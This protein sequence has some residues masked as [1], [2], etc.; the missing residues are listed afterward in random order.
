MVYVLGRLFYY[1][2][3]Y[4]FFSIRRRHTRCALVTGVQTCALPILTRPHAITLDLGDVRSFGG[5]E[6]VVI[7]GD[8]LLAAPAI[9]VEAGVDDQARG[10]EHIG[11][12][13]AELAPRVV[14]VDAHLVGEL[15]GIKAP[16]LGIDRI[17][18]EAAEARDA[19]R[20]LRERDLV[21]MARRRFVIGQRR[22]RPRRVFGGVA[23]VD[24]ISAGARAV[25]SE[26]R[27]VGK[28]CVS[29][30]RSRW[31]PYH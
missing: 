26:E 13:I 18:G 21:V 16:A 14:C 20:L 19:R 28:A 4:F 5:A 6:R 15:F 7:I 9:M 12:Q 27:R 2:F 24:I 17:S 29:K 25:R 22:Q 10:A 23:Q 31:S 8:R 3:F 1:Y 11:L 30:G